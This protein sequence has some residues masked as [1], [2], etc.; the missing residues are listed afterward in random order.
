MYDRQNVSNKSRSRWSFDFPDTEKKDS[1]L[2]IHL[3]ISPSNAPIGHREHTVRTAQKSLNKQKPHVFQEN[4][5]N[6]HNFLRDFIVIHSSIE[7]VHNTERFQEVQG[8]LHTK[9]YPRIFV[10]VFIIGI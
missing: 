4:P 10:F 2:V 6:F 5:Y 1:I 8:I 7:I 3:C 9:M